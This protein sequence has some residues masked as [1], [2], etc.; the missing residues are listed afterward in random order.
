[1]ETVK[2]IS[3][4]IPL[5]KCNT[6]FSNAKDG[7]NNRSVGTELMLTE[8]EGQTINKKRMEIGKENY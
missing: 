2:R 6:K 4:E 5:L 8:F 3:M 1:L 7:I